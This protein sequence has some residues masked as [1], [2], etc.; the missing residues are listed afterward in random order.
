M[1]ETR[2]VGA[3]ALFSARSFGLSCRHCLRQIAPGGE[4]EFLRADTAGWQVRHRATLSPFSPFPLLS[5]L[6]LCPFP[7]LP[8]SKAFGQSRVLR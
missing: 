3:T 5:V 7:P 8:G 4:A 2:L 6:L 1:C